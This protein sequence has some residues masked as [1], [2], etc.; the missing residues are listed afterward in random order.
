MCGV[1]GDDLLSVA[2]CCDL[3]SAFRL[4]ENSRDI[5]REHPRGLLLGSLLSLVHCCL[6]HRPR[7]L[8]AASSCLCHCPGCLLLGLA[9]GLG[10]HAGSL[11]GVLSSSGSLGIGSGLG[12]SL[13]FLF[14][15]ALADPA[16]RLVAHTRRLF[17]LLIPLRFVVRLS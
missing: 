14:R 6:E 9:L 5:D 1:Y 12:L 3:W 17:F 7:L 8:L 13:L 4:K 2:P 15:R 10:Q 11:L 16:Y